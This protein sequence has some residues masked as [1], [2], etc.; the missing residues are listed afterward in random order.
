MERAAVG[1]LGRTFERKG[2][3]SFNS[4]HIR[5]MLSP[6]NYESQFPWFFFQEN[7]SLPSPLS[8]IPHHRVDAETVESMFVRRGNASSLVITWMPVS[9]DIDN[10]PIFNRAVRDSWPRGRNSSCFRNI[11]PSL[12]IY[13]IAFAVCS[14]HTRA[15]TIDEKYSWNW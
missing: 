15:W 5:Q 11:V 6:Y 8:R 7:S 9:H 13:V 2:R 10:R 3:S 14:G 1:Q 4:Q 12:K